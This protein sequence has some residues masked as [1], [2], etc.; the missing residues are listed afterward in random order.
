MVAAGDGIIR[1]N[2]EDG[3]DTIAAGLYAYGVIVGPDGMVYVGGTGPA[4]LK[5]DPESGDWDEFVELPGGTTSRTIDFSPDYS[6][7]Y[8]GV[9]SGGVVYAVDLDESLEPLGDPYVFASGGGLQLPRRPGCRRV[10]QRLRQRLQH[11][12]ALADHPRR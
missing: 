9:L 8:L 4:V 10:R 3:K 7:M 6:K 11:V 1:I 2:P 5:L 12:L